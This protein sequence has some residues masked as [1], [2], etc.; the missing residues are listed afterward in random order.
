MS[1]RLGKGADYHFG[2]SRLRLALSWC[3]L[4]AVVM[5][6]SLAACDRRTKTPASTTPTAPAAPATPEASPERQNT[7]TPRPP[8]VT[9]A[10][11]AS[12]TLTIWGPDFLAPLDE[13]TGG[14]VLAG[15]MRAFETAHPDWAVQYVRKKPSGQG[16]VLHFLR[17]TQAVAPELLPDLALVDM[18]EVG[19][20]ADDSLLQ[21]LEPLLGSDLVSD[22]APFAREAGR[23]GDELVA[24]QYEAD[25]LFLAY[26]STII[27]DAPTTWAEVLASGATYLLPIGASEGAVR[28]AFLPQYLAAGG[29][30][31][32]RNGLPYLDATVIEAILEVYGSARD[33]E[34]FP[35]SGFDL[36]DAS[37]CWPEY[38]SSRIAMTNVSSWDYGRDRANRLAATRVAPLPTLSG[39]QFSL[40]SGWGWVLL[41]KEPSRQAAAAEF[42]RT[43][44]QPQAMAAWSQV[45]YHLPTRRSALPLAV[46][47]TAYQSFLQALMEVTVPQ[48]REPVYSLATDALSSA[49]ESVARGKS[50]PRAAAMEAAERVRAA[51][52][53]PETSSQY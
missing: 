51:Q 17:S 47:D 14:P 49:I 52:E 39:A 5:L 24:V 15:Q 31:V 12:L 13:A 21:P 19:L 46:G 4:L 29:K 36:E 44:L 32:D 34:L 25:L 43:V 53:G 11:T 28:D 42:L 20:L 2:I 6:L 22:L 35:A 45:T 23:V 27:A 10:A 40:S 3:L 37:D 1:T 33:A 41:S 30:L 7:Q 38:L 48:P 8:T 16:G 50:T 18:S 26:N 9:A